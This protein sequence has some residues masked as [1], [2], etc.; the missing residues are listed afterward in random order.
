MVSKKKK[1]NKT[2]IHFEIIMKIR[3]FSL[4]HLFPVNELQ[5]FEEELSLL[6][7]QTG[8]ACEFLACSF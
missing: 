4:T 7:V 1:R 6:H 2:V 8:A 3:C 5:W